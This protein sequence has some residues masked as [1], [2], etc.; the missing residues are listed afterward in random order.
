MSWN[1][2][3]K[4]HKATHGGY[5]DKPTQGQ[6][7]GLMNMYAGIAAVKLPPL[8]EKEIVPIGTQLKLSL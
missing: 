6:V 7:N 3:S 8:P 4:K 1:P 5:R 2:N